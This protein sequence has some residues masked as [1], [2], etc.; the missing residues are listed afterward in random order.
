MN[1]YVIVG[2]KKVPFRQSD[3]GA[4]EFEMG[5]DQITK[6]Q[7]PI[8]NPLTTLEPEFIDNP[9]E[10]VP[11]SLGKDDYF[12][13]I[14]PYRGGNVVRS[15]DA[16]ATH[17]T[18]PDFEERIYNVTKTSA[19]FVVVTKHAIHFSTTFGSGYTTVLALDSLTDPGFDEICIEYHQSGVGRDVFLVGEYSQEKDNVHKLYLSQDGGQTWTKIKDGQIVDNTVNAHWHHATFDPYTGNIFASLGDGVNRALYLS[20]DMGQNWIELSDQNY[21][22]PTLL[23]PFIDR[24]YNGPDSNVNMGVYSITKKQ[25]RLIGDDDFLNEEFFVIDE[26]ITAG[27]GFPTQ[28]YA[29][30]GNETYIVYPSK[31]DQPGAPVYIVATADGGETWHIVYGTKLTSPGS[32]WMHQGIV[33]VNPDGLMMSY[34]RYNGEHY[35]LKFNKLEWNFK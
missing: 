8:A 29:R 6:Q 18:G 2:D 17:E 27:L 13:G 20:R 21:Y 5:S 4:F 12:Y 15:N 7:K 33:G 24:I 14:K 31:L 32:D 16:F 11:M 22:Q 9:D 28:P 23:I 35:L 34:L 10:I 19:G 25:S 3:N 26:T 1:N 30:K